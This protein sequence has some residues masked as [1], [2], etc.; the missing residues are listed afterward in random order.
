MIGATLL[1]W[2][3]WWTERSH[4]ARG[5]LTRPGVLSS[6]VVDFADHTHWQHIPADFQ[7]EHLQLL[8]AVH[9][10][11]KSHRHLCYAAVVLLW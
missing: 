11:L 3:L 1:S 8:I 2:K 9:S 10:V 6:L 4:H 7:T 5:L